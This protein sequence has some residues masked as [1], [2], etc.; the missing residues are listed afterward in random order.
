[1]TD[2]FEK[3]ISILEGRSMSIAN[4]L[5]ALYED[6]K[7]LRDLIYEKQADLSTA[8]RNVRLAVKTD[9]DA[10]AAYETAK[11][12]LID[13]QTKPDGKINGPNADTRKAQASA[14]LVE[15]QRRGGDLYEAYMKMYT[16]EAGLLDANTELDIA[17]DA[18][19]AVKYVAHMISELSSSL[20]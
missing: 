9:K 12:A 10:K 7:G 6:Y 13:S 5:A 15:S 17:V 3:R 1:M 18:F 19:S 20:R 16:A 11:A 8:R 14:L 2:D 4:I